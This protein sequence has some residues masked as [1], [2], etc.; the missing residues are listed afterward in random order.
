M[1]EYRNEYKYIIDAKED[2]L[3][4]SIASGIMERDSHSDVKG[5]YLIRSLYFDN[6]SNRCYYENENGTDPRWKYR[7]RYYDNNTD[8]ISLEKKSKQCGMTKKTSCHLTT[9]EVKLIIEGK[10]A[11]VLSQNIRD[12]QK[13]QSLQ[14]NKNDQHRQNSHSVLHDPHGQKLHMLEELVNNGM[15]P[16]II[17]TYEREPFI[18]PAGNVRVTFDRAISSSKDIDRFL[19]GDYLNRPIMDMGRSIL[20]VKWDEIMPY[21]IKDAL[22]LQRLTWTAFSKFY[23]ACRYHC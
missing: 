18:H 14:N 17:V 12:T 13:I 16:R 9:N 23:M 10:L 6:D 15:K 19:E 20:E 5:R 2:A 11:Q 1:S 7:I 4:S 8:Y 21:Y 22:N 3:L